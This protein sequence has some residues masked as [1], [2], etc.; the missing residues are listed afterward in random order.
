MTAG[1]ALV[2]IDNDAARPALIAGAGDRAAIRF[3]PRARL[4]RPSL[5]AK[6]DPAKRRSKK[7]SVLIVC[8][9]DWGRWQ[10][11]LKGSRKF[12]WRHIQER[13]AERALLRVPI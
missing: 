4:G 7:T 11:T 1:D 5:W 10:L 6:S 13:L 2:P 8:N 9:G 12:F 3:L